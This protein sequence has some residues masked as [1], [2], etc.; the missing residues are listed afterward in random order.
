MGGGGYE[1]DTGKGYTKDDIAAIMGFAG[2]YSGNSLPDIWELFNATK[3][4]NIGAYRRHLFARMKSYAYD[5]HI[6]INTSIY[7]KQ[8]NIKA[9]VELHFNPGEGVAHLALASKG[10]SILAC[11]ARTTQETERVRKH[12]Q[13]LSAM[14]KTRQL[15]DLLHLSK[16]TTRAPADNFW[17]LKMNIATFMSLVW[18]LFGSNFDY[19][20]SLRQIF[21]TL[22]L[23]EVYTLKTSFTPKNCRCITWAI[24]DNG[25]AF[26]DN[27]KTMIDFTS[28]EMS[29][30][31]SYLINMLRYAVPVERAS[32]PKEWQ[33]RD[34][35][36]DNKGQGRSPGGQGTRECTGH[37]PQPRGGYGD[38]AG[39]AS[40]QNNYGQGGF[41]GAAG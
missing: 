6:Q 15:K 27:V 24:L 41:G 13:A 9:I 23:K 7:L 18:V 22:K 5:R 33:R 26:F 35:V 20:K 11:W 29:F 31:Q 25:R 17:E 34:T 10:L 4:E 21:K 32:F 39:G 40:R 30:P 19:Y 36:K 37:N 1:A 2:V 38:G 16:G 28:P 14:E 8:E 3:G 12:E